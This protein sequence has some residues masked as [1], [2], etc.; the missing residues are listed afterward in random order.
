MDTLK[1]PAIKHKPLSI[2]DKVD[3][4]TTLLCTKI[5]ACGICVN[6]MHNYINLR[7]YP[8]VSDEQRAIKKYN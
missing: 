4:A 3:T 5:T 2:Q 6:F 7:Q 8:V 1:K